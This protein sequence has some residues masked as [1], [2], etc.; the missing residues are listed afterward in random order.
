M[1]PATEAF[2]KA[3]NEARGNL[4]EVARMFHVERNTVGVWVRNDEDFKAAVK[5]AR[6]GLFDR[7]LTTAEV[8]ALGVAERD[9][10]GRFVGWKTAPDGQMLRY[11][12]SKI[13]R[14]EGFGDSMDVTTNGK[15]I[16]SQIVFCPTPLTEQDI[17]E[18]KEIQDGQKGA[19]DAGISET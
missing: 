5:S 18:M 11:L 13:G 3:V 8:V 9:K 6:L 7:C 12:I 19:G 16:G 2:V 1:K 14:D 17:R 15:D 10:D 4:S